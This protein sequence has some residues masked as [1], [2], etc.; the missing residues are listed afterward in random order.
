MGVPL[1][2]DRIGVKAE[3]PAKAAG[4]IPFGDVFAKAD[5]AGPA[6]KARGARP[7]AVQ[8]RI[9][10]ADGRGKNIRSWPGVKRSRA[11]SMSRIATVSAR[12]V[13][14]GTLMMPAAVTWP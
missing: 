14:G 8:P 11:G 5:T 4:L 10:R 2:R 9:Q 6:Q 13:S 7:V 3:G 12:M 1:W